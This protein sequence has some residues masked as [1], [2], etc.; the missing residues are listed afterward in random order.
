MHANT[1]QNAAICSSPLAGLNPQQLLEAPGLRTVLRSNDFGQWDSLVA[2]SLG[3]HRSRLLPGSAPFNAQIRMGA[4]EEF[5]VLLLHGRGQIELVR[6]QCGHGVLWLPLQGLSQETINGNACVAEPGM[7][8]LFQPGDAMRGLTSEEVSGISILV[9]QEHLLG[10]TPRSP[11]LQ[12]GRLER[13][14]IAAGLQLAEAAAW[15]PQGS[16]HAAEALVEAL[17]QCRNPPDPGQ[18][19]ERI[20]SMRRRSTVAEA[21]RWID[22]HLAERFSVDHL[23]SAVGVSARTLQYSFLQELGHSPMAEA[24]R[25]RLR[26]LRRLL[27]DPDQKH[28][29]ISELM[30][31]SGLLACGIT[32]ADYRR[33]CGESP[34][35]TRRN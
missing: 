27:Q 34:R 32:A 31:A 13:Q 2:H 26:Q 5:Q 23:S 19:R 35:R 6:E 21:C 33:W 15:Q 8:L 9:P 4:V 28:R 14:L 10:A 25:V 7:A 30:E 12:R 22:Q 20:T 24:K 29:S 16:R 17:H 3:H 11:L 1:R 18:Q